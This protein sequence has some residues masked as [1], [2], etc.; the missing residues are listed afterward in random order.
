MKPCGCTGGVSKPTA[1]RYHTNNNS[2]YSASFQKRGSML[3]WSGSD[4]TWLAAPDGSPSRLA[5]LLNLP[6]FAG[7]RLGV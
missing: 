3:I 6:G 4:M 1:A 5:V 2:R 7:D